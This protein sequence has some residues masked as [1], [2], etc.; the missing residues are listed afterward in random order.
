M[1]GNLTQLGATTFNRGAGGTVHLDS[2]SLHNG[3]NFSI[4][5]GDELTQSATVSGA[6]SQLQINT[7]L[8][9][10]SL[11][12]NTGGH[13]N[14]TSHLSTNSVNLNGATLDLSNGMTVAGSMTVDAGSFLNLHG[15]TLSAT[16]ELSLSNSSL[17]RGVGG[18]VQVG[19][20]S[21]SQSSMTHEGADTIASQL[22]VQSG[23]TMTL[24]KNLSMPAGNVFAQ[25]G[26]AIDL[27]GHSLTA[28]NLTLAGG[29]VTRGAGGTVHLD[30]LSLHNG[31]NFSI[32]P[33]DE[34]TQSATVS[35]A[36]TT[37]DINT[38]LTL[39]SLAANT[40]ALVTVTQLPGVSTG[41]TLEQS[42]SLDASSRLALVGPSA[43]PGDWMLRWSQDHVAELLAM[44]A[45]GR[46]TWT[47]NLPVEIVAGGDGYSYVMAVPEPTTYVLAAI[48]IAGLV[49]VGR[50]PRRVRQKVSSKPWG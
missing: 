38:S 15:S 39:Q 12:L 36:G 28:V 11:T 22:L 13:V 35:G 49:L 3:S 19:F 40:S 14:A 8:T 1:A 37:L 20:L 17:D 16:N 6:G 45:D 9:F 46:L 26:G 43:V 24:E 4:E 5:P 30:S 33:G 10:N 47:S 34:L 48:G 42:L 2:L 23:A 32:E 29:V 50:L 21:L 41:L 31:S 7:P 18:A 27:N 25:N 44:H